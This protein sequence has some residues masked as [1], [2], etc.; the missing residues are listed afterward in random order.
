MFCS[1]MLPLRSFFSSWC[2][3]NFFFSFSY[4]VVKGKRDTHSKLSFFPFSY[5]VVKTV[6]F[7]CCYN[8]IMCIVFSVCFAACILF[9][10]LFSIFSVAWSVPATVLYHLAYNDTV[11]ICLLLVLLFG[12]ITP[13]VWFN[14]IESK[15]SPLI[16]CFEKGP[17]RLLHYFH[18]FTTN[19]T[20]VRVYVVG[21][22]VKFASV[23][24]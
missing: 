16:H 3:L 12:S 2:S 9:Y 6:I 11:L 10:M 15:V 24:L 4:S 19:Y 5:S 22:W 21:V 18:H 17:V 14:I 7:W 1:S 8:Q 23:S 13:C 20:C